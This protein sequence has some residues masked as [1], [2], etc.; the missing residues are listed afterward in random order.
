MAKLRVEGSLPPEPAVVVSDPGG[1]VRQA[2]E[3]TVRVEVLVQLIPA[4][5]LAGRGANRAPQPAKVASETD[6]SVERTVSSR[7]CAITSRRPCS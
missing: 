6:A 5:P 3:P 4:A 2:T 1:V 7:L